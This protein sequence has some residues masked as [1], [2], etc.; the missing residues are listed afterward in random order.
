MDEQIIHD[1]DAKLK[2]IETDPTFDVNMMDTI[3]YNDDDVSMH[4]YTE[5]YSYAEEQSNGIR[6]RKETGKNKQLSPNKI[7]TVKMDEP[8]GD[9]SASPDYD[10]NHTGN[11]SKEH[12]NTM[13][14]PSLIQK[15]LQP[16]T[17][18]YEFA[19]FRSKQ[20]VSKGEQHDEEE[21]DN[22]EHQEAQL[23][24]YNPYETSKAISSSGNE[25]QKYENIIIHNHF[26]NIVHPGMNSDPALNFVEDKFIDEIEDN[27]Q[28]GVRNIQTFE[29]VKKAINY[30]MIILFGYIIIRQLSVDISQEYQKLQI[31]EMY[32]RDQCRHEYDINNCDE[33]GQLPALKNECLE[34]KICFS[35]GS[36]DQ[37][38]S[39]F[40]SELAIRVLSKII[41]E[42]LESIGMINRVFLVGALIIWYM[43]NFLCGYVKGL[44][45]GKM[46][47]DRDNRTNSNIERNS[48]TTDLIRL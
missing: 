19:L 17:Q 13:Q 33:Y 28:V 5:D 4:D 25:K 40:Y 24:Q 6:N 1:L 7:D 16:E 44:A 39:I 9:L 38:T 47:G 45:K 18:G 30:S 26:Y 31:R 3:E 46:F 48:K 41:N 29:N 35:E 15:I 43:G 2:F 8:V 34:W 37:L 27:A 20:S 32:E 14:S 10:T 12:S 21:E 22:E 42:S 36:T 23:K 11:N